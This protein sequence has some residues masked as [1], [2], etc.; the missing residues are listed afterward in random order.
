MKSPAKTSQA[1]AVVVRHGPIRDE[2]IGL[3]A[4]LLLEALVADQA[5]ED[6]GPDQDAPP[7]IVPLRRATP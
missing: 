4:D 3:L 2:G 6:D 7:D 5:G 1:P